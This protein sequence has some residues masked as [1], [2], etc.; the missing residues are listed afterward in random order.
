MQ[1]ILVDNKIIEI[2]NNEIASKIIPVVLINTFENEG[3][4]IWKETKKLCNK[5]FIL[6]AISNIDWNK[7]MSPWKIKEN[8]EYFGKADNYLKELENDIIP[9]VTEFIN[10]NLNMK[11]KNFIIAGYSMAG[12]FALYSLYKT[13]IFDKMAS[14]SGSLWYPNL[15]DFIKENELKSNVQKMYFSL[16]N[17]ESK[18]KNMLFTNVE[19]NTKFI[20]NYFENLGINAIYEENNGNH[21][22]NSDIRMAKAIK[23]LLED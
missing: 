6:V 13:S 23:W 17:M 15:V 5:E 16:G 20:K 14:V 7:D 2:F 21:F 22:Q 18:T 1:K 11:I 3:Y 19:K 12:L 4:N 10:K 9:K 8:K